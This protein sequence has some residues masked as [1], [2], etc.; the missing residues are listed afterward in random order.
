MILLTQQPAAMTSHND[1]IRL[2]RRREAVIA[3]HALR[4]RDAAAHLDALRL[5]SE[6][7]TAWTTQNEASLD[8]KLRHYLSN[9]SFAKA[10]AHLDAP[11]AG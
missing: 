1:L 8:P 4:D 11:A 2:L 3:D 10:L 7:I 6:E 9:A 5:V